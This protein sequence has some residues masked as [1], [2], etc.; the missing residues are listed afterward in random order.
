MNKL[1]F[2]R[3]AIGFEYV[4]GFQIVFL[5]QSFCVKTIDAF[6][7]FCSVTASI[8]VAT[9]AMKANDAPSTN[10]KKDQIFHRSK[11]VR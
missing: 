2:I 6:R 10:V 4:F 8:I 1:K 3:F 9:V 5:V 7:S 11:Y